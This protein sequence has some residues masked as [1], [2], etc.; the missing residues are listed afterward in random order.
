MA[1]I[2]TMATLPEMWN[3]QETSELGQQDLIL[4]SWTPSY[5]EI[6]NLNQIEIKLAAIQISYFLNFS[7]L[8]TS[9]YNLLNIF[10]EFMSIII[11]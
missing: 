1:N 10:K 7:W 6:Y 2:F 5:K 9:I 11:V 4:I 8:L 3:V